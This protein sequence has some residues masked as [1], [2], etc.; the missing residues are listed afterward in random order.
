[1]EVKP[2]AAVFAEF[3]FAEADGVNTIEGYAA[4][5]NNIDAGGD[6]IKPGAFAEFLSARG[7]NPDPVPMFYEH[8]PDMTA[9]IWTS[10]VED[11]KGLLA[12]G[13][14]LDTTLGR[15]TRVE[16][17]KRAKTGLSIGYTTLQ[18]TPRV[19]AADPRRT[20]TKLHLWEASVTA[21]PLNDKARVLNVKSSAPSE[22]EKVLRDAGLSKREAKV[23][24]AEGFP[25][26]KSLRDAGDHDDELADL[27]RR[28]I[29][30]LKGV[31]K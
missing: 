22:F 7:P 8:N 2:L 4:H 26:L 13:E 11:G 3:K 10:L 14:F 12:K 15:D 25:G 31:A 27:I 24:M 19:N 6:L 28:N 5:F 20:I 18:S 30:Q 1:M 29:N 21:F 17:Q 16:M 23:F 9:G